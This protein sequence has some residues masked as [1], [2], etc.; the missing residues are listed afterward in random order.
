[1][2]A[3][4]RAGVDAHSCGS[5]DTEGSPDVFVNGYPA[6]RM[7]DADSH[8]GSQ[9]EGSGTVFVNGR[10]IARLGDNNGGCPA[11]CAPNPEASGS[12]NVFAG[13]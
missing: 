8:G 13:G 2:K 1:M 12:T 7:G 11:P 6:H 5:L 4:C 10:P 3:V 9:A